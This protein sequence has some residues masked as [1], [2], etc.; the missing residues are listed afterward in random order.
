MKHRGVLRSMSIARGKSLCF[1]F[2]VAV[3]L[4]Q[5]NQTAARAQALETFDGSNS[6]FTKTYFF[7]VP[8]RPDEGVFDIEDLSGVAG[9]TVTRPSLPIN[10]GGDKELRFH[11]SQL[12]SRFSNYMMLSESEPIP[13]WSTDSQKMGG[14][15]A[16]TREGNGW[17]GGL[18]LRGQDGGGFTF[19]NGYVATVT[20]TPVAGVTLTIYRMTGGILV[21][22]AETTASASTDENYRVEFEAEGTLLT[23]R[24]FQLR[25]VA[26]QIQESLLSSLSAIDSTYA[27][28]SCAGLLAF[29]NGTDSV[30]FDNIVLGAVKPA[31]PVLNTAPASQ[32]VAEGALAQFTAQASNTEEYQWL[33]DGVE[34]PG[35]TTSTL[36]LGSFQVQDQ[37]LYHVRLN[38]P[39]GVVVVPAVQFHMQPKIRVQPASV[40]AK[41]GSTV[42]L[43]VD[44]IYAVSFQWLKDNYPIPGATSSALTLANISPSDVDSYQVS[45]VGTGGA[46]LSA[47]A[48][49]TL[50]SSRLV[51]LSV[52]SRA[53]K[54]DKTLIMGFVI[55]GN[56]TKQ[57]LIRGI[58]PTLI[59][60]GV[61]A[62]LSDP[63]LKLYDR[64]S[65]K[66][67]END[68]WGGTAA[69]RNKYVELG[70]SPL[71]DNSKDA[72]L[73]TSLTGGPYT[74]H[75]TTLDASTGIALV[76]IYD[77]ASDESTRLV[78]VSARSEALTGDDILIA[79]FVLSGNAPKTLLIRGLGPALT[80]LGVAGALAD[81]Q[82]SL[83]NRTGTKLSENDNWGGT[84]AMKDVFAVIGAGKL[85]S[86]TSKDA[87]F[88]VTLEPGVYTVHVSGVNNTTG[89]A[90][91]EIFEVP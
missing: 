83:Y 86:D 45:V 8:A 28:G 91:V 38:G 26:G 77:A 56:G 2:I 57:V 3:L 54:D 29:V 84:T 13:N 6:L 63:Q 68:N 10:A 55:A 4:G 7:H 50:S 69:L 14:T 64:N 76:E 30:L 37:G 52:R 15:I 33:K 58:G 89:V 23:A 27:S 11:K 31:A 61:P 18:L 42:T 79:G 81:P 80:A 88:L 51:N 36:S 17:G 74:A 46:V 59:A 9:V 41:P 78:N 22:L 1:L 39:G 47:V 49:L 40:A 35:A 16:F 53:G 71:D 12:S 87:A 75:V 44:A 85:T 66:L 48:T 73:V 70:A 25:V 72:A 62:A 67:A 32:Q 21:S 19:V 60:A 65:I 43:S 34:I 24:F 5:L 82:I 20:A 90:L